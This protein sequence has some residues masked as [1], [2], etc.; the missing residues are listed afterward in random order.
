MTK[1]Q[2]YTEEEVPNEWEDWG[3]AVES[4]PDSWGDVFLDNMQYIVTYQW[5]E[6][7]S[8]LDE[9]GVTS[10]FPSLNSYQTFKDLKEL[11]Q[12]ENIFILPEQNTVS[13]L[14]LQEILLTI[15]LRP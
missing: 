10:L 15:T 9:N 13:F 12:L 1:N 14:E 8:F 2:E 4:N 7:E 6:Q 11:W 3:K 5:K